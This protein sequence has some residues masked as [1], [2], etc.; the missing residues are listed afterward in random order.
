MASVFM[1]QKKKKYVLQD[2]FT[3]TQVFSTELLFTFIVV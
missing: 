3:F 2:V 1:A